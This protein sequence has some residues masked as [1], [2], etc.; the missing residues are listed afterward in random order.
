[1]VDWSIGPARGKAFDSLLPLRAK[2]QNW[3][4]KSGLWEEKV[5]NFSNQ[6]HEFE[7]FANFLNFFLANRTNLELKFIE[8]FDFFAFSNQS[9]RKFSN[10]IERISNE[11]Q[12]DSTP[13]VVPNQKNS[14]ELFDRF[15]I[16]VIRSVAVL[17]GH[18]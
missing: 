12:F 4:A 2:T 11:F 3:K 7:K 15:S 5:S 16:S 14:P 10:R 13:I 18:Q 6:K 1:M 17:Y 9:N 8:Y